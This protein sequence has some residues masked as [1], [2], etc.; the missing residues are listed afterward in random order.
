M[1]ESPRQPTASFSVGSGEY[2]HELD[3]DY[4]EDDDDDGIVIGGFRRVNSDEPLD[5]PDS[6]G[7]QDFENIIGNEI[8]T[9]EN[10]IVQP[11][12]TAQPRPQYKIIHDWLFG[13]VLG[14]GS[15]AKV[16]EV[17]HTQTLVG[18]IS[19]RLKTI[20]KQL[21]LFRSELLSKLSKNVV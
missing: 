15:Y 10:L 3:E 7:G 1:N 17:L 8:G 12:I 19:I 13:S 20:K 16:K 5:F 14:E 21:N 2:R 11:T 18:L 6:I 9:L 4:N